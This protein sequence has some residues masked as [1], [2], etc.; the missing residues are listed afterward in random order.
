MCEIPRTVWAPPPPLGTHDFRNYRSRPSS[1]HEG[2]RLPDFPSLRVARFKV[3]EMIPPARN[4]PH[5]VIPVLRVID[6]THRNRDFLITR[7]PS[8]ARGAPMVS[9]V[10]SHPVGNC[11]GAQVLQDGN[12]DFQISQF[13]DMSF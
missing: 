12:R 7:A 8:A 4:S 5:V 1:F 6:A 11:S 10:I 13:P 9:T 3:T 2:P